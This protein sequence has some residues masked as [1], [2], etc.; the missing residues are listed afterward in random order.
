M[1]EA[2]LIGPSQ[3]L[4]SQLQS[5]CTTST[6][7]VV[8]QSLSSYGGRYEIIRLLNL[9]DPKVVFLE[10]GVLSEA[11]RIAKE[12]RA[13]NPQTRIVGFA[14]ECDSEQT[15]ALKEAGVGS[16]LLYPFTAHK[17][18]QAV[19]EALESGR[20][21]TPGTLLAFLPAKAGSGAS[22]AALNLGG[23][24]ASEHRRKVLLIDADLHSGVQALLTGCQ[25][26]STIIDAL[27][28]AQ[29]LDTGAWKSLA[30]RTNGLDLLA[31]PA[32]SKSVVHLFSSWDYFH[33]LSFTLARY[34]YVIV[35]LPEIVND[36]TEAVVKRANSVFLVCTP[37]L[38]SLSLAR[39]RIQE[40]LAREVEEDHLKVVLN[41]STVMGVTGR[42]IQ[43]ILGRR[44]S[45]SLPNDYP[46]VCKAGLTGKRL[47][48]SSK[49]ARSFVG[50]AEK[51]VEEKAVGV[52]RAA[53][54]VSTDLS[55][56]GQG[57]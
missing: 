38:A 43:R 21:H 48:G 39:R 37:E 26:G 49:I 50:F 10:A 13:A 18:R 47:A 6:G 32:T 22:T 16:I 15:A 40:I 29:A 3:D 23:S 2:A 28:N 11:L 8:Y 24:L 53:E 33:L 54:R 17:I 14:R 45:V 52:A 57:V 5:L 25:P 56:C 36:A 1:L 42:D 41:R 34:D 19:A 55:W 7:L 46:R 44:E 20:Q 4:S 12:I 9:A 31:A 35:D 27:R 30:V 51:V